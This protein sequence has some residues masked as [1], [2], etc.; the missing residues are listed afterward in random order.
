MIPLNPIKAMADGDMLGIIFWSILFGFSITR[1][2]GKPQEFF[3]NF[4][5]YGFKAMMKL[6][7]GIIA[8][9]PIGVFGLITTAVANSGIDVF[10]AVGKYI[11]TISIGLSIHFLVILPLVFFIFTKINP[12]KH[13]KAMVSRFCHRIFNQF[14][15]CY[16]TSNN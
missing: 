7:Q 4:F 1:L 10:K 8:L 16:T 11:I 5:A 9:L 6:T 15:W 14:I 12:L 13:W 3:I 2:S